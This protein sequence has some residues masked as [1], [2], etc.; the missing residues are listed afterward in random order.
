MGHGEIVD[1]MVH[2]GLWDAYENFHMGNTGELV[3]EKYSI[4]RQEQDEYACRSHQKAVLWLHLGHLVGQVG[5]VATE[6]SSMMVIFRSV[7]CFVCRSMEFSSV[8]LI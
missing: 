3:A 5:S 1:A 8:G 7:I 4:T 2:D 6:G